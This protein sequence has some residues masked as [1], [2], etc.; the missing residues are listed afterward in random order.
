M[1]TKKKAKVEAVGDSEITTAKD[2]AGIVTASGRVSLGIDDPV[3]RASDAPI[4]FSASVFLQAVQDP[5]VVAVGHLTFPPGRIPT[6]ADVQVGLKGA[7]DSMAAAAKESGDSY[8]FKPLGRSSF[9]ADVCQVP[10]DKRGAFGPHEFLLD[11]TS[12]IN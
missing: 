11:G 1:S 10:A 3:L 6:A 5:E 7:C 12:A 9:I 2:D 8:T 4:I